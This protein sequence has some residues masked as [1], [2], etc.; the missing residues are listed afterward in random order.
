MWQK[1]DVIG[2][3]NIQSLVFPEGIRYNRESD[4]VRTD[5][6]NSYFSVISSLSAFLEGVK[7]KGKRSEDTF[8]DL[9]G[10][11]GLEPGTY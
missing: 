7:E 1:A 2:K 8:P 6:V 11:P 4:T 3:Q 10:P 9:V 5:R